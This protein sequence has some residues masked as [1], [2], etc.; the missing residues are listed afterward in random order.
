MLPETPIQQKDA[1]WKLAERL[2]AWK[3][4]G[5]H[6]IRGA[7]HWKVW[8]TQYPQLRPLLG[9]MFT[10]G[11]KESTLDIRSIAQ[12]AF[13]RSLIN[14]LNRHLSIASFVIVI[15]GNDITPP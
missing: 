5:P 13:F 9:A 8:A 15:T 1:R 12:V 3:A 4:L 2:A 10:A 6:A 11:G 14:L 7:N